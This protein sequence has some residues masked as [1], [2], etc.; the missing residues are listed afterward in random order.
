[1]PVVDEID[2]VLRVL[3]DKGPYNGVVFHKLFKLGMLLSDAD[4]IKRYGSGLLAPIDADEDDD[5]GDDSMDILLVQDD[6]TVVVPAVAVAADVIDVVHVDV[7]DSAE[8]DE[9]DD[10]PGFNDFLA[11]YND[12]PVAE[13]SV[14]TTPVTVTSVV[15]APVAEEPVVTAATQVV[16]AVVADDD[17]VDETVAEADYWF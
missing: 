2:S 10:L 14:I 9:F 15:T 17:A 1:M 11:K 3:P 13:E 7:N 8:V 4:K 6:V 12:T 5:E 16:T